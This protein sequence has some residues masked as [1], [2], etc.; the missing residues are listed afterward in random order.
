MIKGFRGKR[1]TARQRE[2]LSAIAFGDRA[3]HAMAL[4]SGQVLRD[5]HGWSAE[6]VTEFVQDVAAQ[7]RQN[8]AEFA[9][10]RNAAAN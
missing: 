9:E 10:A 7:V 6:Q 4:A 1:V 8:E 2:Q 3:I 5:K